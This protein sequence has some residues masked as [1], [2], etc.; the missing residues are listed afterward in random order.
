[1]YDGFGV[2]TFPNGIKIE[3]FWKNG[4][5]QDCNVDYQKCRLTSYNKIFVELLNCYQKQTDPSPEEPLWTKLPSI[6]TRPSDSNCVPHP[7]INK[8]KSLYENILSI[9]KD[10]WELILKNWKNNTRPNIDEIDSNLFHICKELLDSA[11]AFEFTD[12]VDE[13]KSGTE[14]HKA[15]VIERYNMKDGLKT[16]LVLA[17]LD[18]S[19]H[20]QNNESQFNDWECLLSTWRKDLTLSEKE[21]KKLIIRFIMNRS[22]E[23][24][25][26]NN[27]EVT[28]VIDLN[29]A[30]NTLHDLLKSQVIDEPEGNGLYSAILE[31]QKNHSKEMEQEL[32]DITIIF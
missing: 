18:S 11:K 27:K 17:I 10:K 28:G 1:M 8:I 16:L 22:Y 7:D 5:A 26:G 32:N 4:K 6:K 2:K 9:D 12:K 3:G 24:I 23:R 30:L 21:Q 29:A 20:V 25:D 31:Q 13:I 15:E 19:K 14:K